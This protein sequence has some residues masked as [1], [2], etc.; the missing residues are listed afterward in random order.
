MV[1]HFLRLRNFFRPPTGLISVC[2][3]T[4]FFVRNKI[5]EVV[6]CENLLTA[7]HGLCDR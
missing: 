1:F 2:K 7:I 6:E 3:G 5:S 4:A